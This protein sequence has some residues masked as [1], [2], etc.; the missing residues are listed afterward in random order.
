VLTEPSPR[1]LIALATYNESDTLPELLTAIHHHA[2]TAEVLVIDDASP[3]GT[4]A[5][6]DALARDRPWLHVLHRP[7]KL[8]L[9][10]ALLTAMQ[11]AMT[12]GYDL[13]VTMDADGS[14][15]P[16]YLPELLAGMDR[17]DVMIGSRY[18]RGGGVINWPASRQWLS[19]GV[20]T[21]VRVLMRLP[22]RDC[23]G[24]YRCYRVARLRQARLERM[25]SHGYSF[26]EE[27]L[28]RCRQAGA[29]IGE[30][31][32]VF[33]NRRRGASKVNRREMARSLA[34]LLYLG[35]K[36]FFGLDS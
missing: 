15:A 35:V 27:V 17:R 36:A 1:L 18:V 9:G 2:P 5:L 11:Q 34:I 24:G 31:P 29:T 30:T 33:E 8:G 16:R 20:N 19:W 28:Y 14:H 7:G 26:E 6:A 10:T 13:L 22:A 12:G 3:D 21:M 23:S 25:L 32:I 4:G